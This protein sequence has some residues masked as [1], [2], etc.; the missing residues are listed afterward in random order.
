MP[1]VFDSLT[2]DLVGGNSSGPSGGGQAQ[3]PSNKDKDNDSGSGNIS[4][5]SR[6][7][8][9]SDNPPFYDVM[10]QKDVPNTGTEAKPHFNIDAPNTDWTK[11]NIELWLPKAGDVDGDPCFNN[12]YQQQVTRE[13]NCNTFRQRVAL[14]MEKAGCPSYITPKPFANQTGCCGCAQQPVYPAYQPP[15][16]TQTTGGGGCSGTSCPLVSYPA[17]PAN[18][19][20]C[21]P[22][23]P[24]PVSST[25]DPAITAVIGKPAPCTTEKCI[26]DTTSD[27]AIT[28]RLP[29]T[30]KWWEPGSTHSMASSGT[31]GTSSINPS[32]D[33]SCHS[34][35]SMGSFHDSVSTFGNSNS[36]MP[37]FH[38]NSLHDD[39]LHSMDASARGCPPTFDDAD[40]TRLRLFVRPDAPPSSLAAAVAASLPTPGVPVA[41]SMPT[42][43][44]A[45]PC[46][47]TPMDDDQL[48]TR[49]SGA[50]CY[51]PGGSGKY[52]R[53]DRGVDPMDHNLWR[54][55]NPDRDNP[56]DN[57]IQS[58]NPC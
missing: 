2:Q 10:N 9:G 12:C 31:I 29:D 47:P 5:K 4:N 38:G 17:V 50:S 7:G 46:S 34:N 18:A 49:L 28:G 37:S 24:D 58:T 23:V 30:T 48:R 42:R 8:T 15:A 33:N 3:Y 56:I 25:S 55:N 20:S 40:L 11:D 16:Y 27:P 35:A 43:V 51:G 52:M 54:R 57:A 41:A 45:A 36:S 39:S 32:L 13:A 14:A 6:Y 22:P 26:P 44:R 19:K 53:V 1:D 21:P